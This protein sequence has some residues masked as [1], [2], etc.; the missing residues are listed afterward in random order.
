MK[1]QTKKTE[2][3]SGKTQRK[4]SEKRR[5]D[6]AT[7]LKAQ[8]EDQQHSNHAF[9]IVGVGA[10]A[11]GLEAFREFLAHLPDDTGMA[12]VLVQHLDP[13]HESML[14]ELLSRSTELPVS[15]VEDGM[16]VAPNHIYVIPRNSEMTIHDGVLQL[17]PRAEGRSQH[18]SIDKFLRSLAEDQTNRAIGI[19]L[20]GTAT[21]GTLG[22]EAIKAEGGITFAQSAASAK[23]DGMPRSA[24]ASGCVDFV[25]APKAIAGELARI[26]KHPYVVA[27]EKPKS[28]E[29]EHLE[30][31]GNGFKRILRILKKAH[32]VDFTLYKA[33]TLERRT[34]RRMLLNKIEGYDDYARYLDAHPAEVENLYQDIL[35]N[36]TSFFRHPETFALLKKNIFPQIIERRSNEDPV[37]IWVLGCSTGEEAYSIAMAFA[38][39]AN[40]R[41]DH[42]PVQ[43]FATDVN[44]RGI[45]RARAG[46][47]SKNI[48]EDISADRLRR[49]FIEEDGG[50]RVSKPIRDMCVFAQQNVLADPPFSRMDLISCRN[51]L[52]YLEPM[53]QKKVIPLLHYALNPN[54]F[55]WLGSSETVGSSTDLFEAEDKKHRFYSKKPSRARRRF[56]FPLGTLAHRR[57]IVDRASIRKAGG[58]E[59]DALGEADRIIMSRFA[60]ASVLI[61]DAFEILQFRG[62]TAAYLE[63]PPGKATLNVLKMASEGLL[64]ALRA[65]LVKARK[66]NQVVRKEHLRVKADGSMQDVS[67]EVIPIRHG[68]PLERYFLILLESA[69]TAAEKKTKGKQLLAKPETDEAD[70]KVLRE[71]LASTR[72]YLQSVIEQYE[73]ATEELQSA[74]E[75]I[76]SSN[77][78]LQSINEELETAKEELESSNEE[79]TTVNEELQNRN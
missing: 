29:V 18:Y 67:L 4:V 51:L 61:N 78:E 33:S 13:K 20:S 56:D 40:E 46:L 43:I 28:K 30:P 75:E 38:E 7:K 77:E 66:N 58:D 79:L 39:L 74:N 60:P 11:G 50:Y 73:A 31:T 54:G 22:L 62:R 12:L 5:H 55:M 48:T 53:A 69:G 19:I 44:D 14:A 15:E 65:A 72:E 32:G 76:Q 52:I 34:L 36:V 8:P 17:D 26:S 1:R 9:P 64:V 47:Y 41:A 71:E 37:R 10:S 2:A 21:D 6:K 57:E 24:I 3:R 35:I 16:P 59:T 63:P 45:E 42:I 49:F 70:V 68:P 27:L 25:L 23:Y